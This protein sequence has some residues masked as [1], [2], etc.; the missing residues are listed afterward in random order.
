VEN[1]LKECNAGAKFKDDKGFIDALTYYNELYKNGFINEDAAT[2]AD[3]W[4]RFLQGKAAL[5]PNVTSVL[6]DAVTALKDDVGAIKPPEINDSATIKDGAIGGPGQCIAVSKNS[7]HP[8]IAV[9]FL[10]FLN[11]K[12][13]T[14]QYEKIQT[15]NPLRKDITIQD[16]GWDANSLAAKV[17]GWSKDYQYFV[18]NIQTPDVNAEF[19]KLAPMVMVGKMTP[20]EFADKLDKAAEK[21]KK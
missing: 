10:S 11:S 2:S 1:I 15:R 18:D 17:F 6:N 20:Q 3:S 5:L 12:S 21:A 4:N 14:L 8:D 16:L 7:E 9:K 13:E 19:C